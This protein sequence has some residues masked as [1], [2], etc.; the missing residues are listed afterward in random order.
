MKGM[1]GEYGPPGPQVGKPM[2]ENPILIRL[3]SFDSLLEMAQAHFLQPGPSM[4]R[5]L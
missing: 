3:I 2:V 1:K 5:N 4:T